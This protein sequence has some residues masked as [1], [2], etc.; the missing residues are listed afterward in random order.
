MEMRYVVAVMIIA[1]PF[2]WFI[3]FI[4]T[5]VAVVRLQ[6]ELYQRFPD[7]SSE[8]LGTRKA[9]G[10]LNKKRGF[11]F[12]W[13]DDV[14]QLVAAYDDLEKQRRFAANCILIG[15]SV[16]ALLAVVFISIILIAERGS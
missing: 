1:L 12:L 15:L 3:Y 7:K 14:K 11:L 5:F 6:N 16:M 13:D 10:L 9:F 2:L 4:S 8:L